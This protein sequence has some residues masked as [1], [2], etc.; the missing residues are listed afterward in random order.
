LRRPGGCY[1]RR[2]GSDRSLQ[3]TALVNEAY[4]RMASWPGFEYRDRAPFFGAA[5]M[6]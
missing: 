3:P 1:L 4:I 5:A 2:E 6:V